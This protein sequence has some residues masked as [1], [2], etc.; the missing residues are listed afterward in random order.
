VLSSLLKSN[1]KLNLIEKFELFHKGVGQNAEGF[2]NDYRVPN[3][4]RM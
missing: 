1:E 4:N 3:E 2:W